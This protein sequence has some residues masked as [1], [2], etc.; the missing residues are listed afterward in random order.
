MNPYYYLFYKL[1]CFLNKK[2]NNEMGTIFGISIYFVWSIIVI[3]GLLVDTRDNISSG[4]YKIV[5]VIICTSLFIT[6]CILFSNKKRVK[7]IINHYK[8][9]TERNRKLG[10]L[11]VILYAII[12]FA[13]LICL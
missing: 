11:I 9:E 1:N 10:N 5:F 3:Y 4:F 12:S 8:V 7:K 13:L 6:N 2:G